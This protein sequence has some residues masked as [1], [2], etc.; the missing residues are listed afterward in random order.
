MN[1]SQSRAAGGRMKTFVPRRDD[2]VLPSPLSPIAR[3]CLRTRLGDRLG[4]VEFSEV[5]L[6]LLRELARLRVV[7]GGVL[8]G[9]ARIEHLARHVGATVGDLH[10]EDRVRR[11]AR[12]AELAWENGRD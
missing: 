4:D 6:E 11:E 1:S 7:V 2:T 8:P 5:L 3:S 10:A 12:V 9:A